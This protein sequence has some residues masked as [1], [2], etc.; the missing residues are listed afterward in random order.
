MLKALEHVQ[1]LW[2]NMTEVEVYKNGSGQQRRRKPTRQAIQS[3]AF[4]IT[5]RRGQ[6]RLDG[7]MD[8]QEFIFR[9]GKVFAYFLYGIGRQTALL[10]ARALTYDPYRQTWEKRL[11]RYLSWQWRTR[12]HVGN[13]T[14]SYR[15]ETLLDAIG[16]QVHTRRLAW[17]RERLEKS[18]DTIHED[19][20]L[21]AWQYNYIDE[22]YWPRSTVLIEPPDII[23][24]TYHRIEQHEKPKLKS[25]PISNTLGE[26]IRRRRKELR[27]SQIQTAEQLEISQAY[28]SLL[29]RGK[30]ENYS[31]KL[32]KKL[33]A[34][35]GEP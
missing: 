21:A 26:R 14:Q 2:L 25:L 35:L 8:V 32:K 5:D 19:G 16:Q 17:Q 33:E 29:E 6:L 9:P 24:E 31:A 4:V 20:A 15:V 23:R 22:T 10:S 7:W 13:Y 34:W 12:A 30:K 11:T 1:N 18:L 27:L 28:L 3:R